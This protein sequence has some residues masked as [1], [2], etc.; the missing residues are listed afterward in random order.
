MVVPVRVWP[1]VQRSDK[2][3][4]VN[5]ENYGLVNLYKPKIKRHWV[6]SKM[7]AWKDK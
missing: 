3:T 6:V 5:S 1:G 4:D 2:D 7:T